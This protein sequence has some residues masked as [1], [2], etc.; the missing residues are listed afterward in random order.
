M[1][2]NADTAFAVKVQLEA[3]ESGLS[4]LVQITED[5]DLTMIHREIERQIDRAEKAWV[6]SLVREAERDGELVGSS[7]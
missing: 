5:E 2:V 7:H 3:I 4:A 1:E 6:A